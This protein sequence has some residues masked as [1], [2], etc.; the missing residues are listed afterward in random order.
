ML[1]I[2][3]RFYQWR[4]EDSHIAL[5]EYLDDEESSEDEKNRLKESM[6]LENRDIGGVFDILDIVPQ[7]L[8]QLGFSTLSI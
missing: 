4:M 7:E 1:P 6:M 5:L 8:L 2:G 3:G